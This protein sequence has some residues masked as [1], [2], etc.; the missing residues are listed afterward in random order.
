MLRVP[1]IK[2]SVKYSHEVL[3]S[4]L[5]QVSSSIETYEVLKNCFDKD[6]FFMQEQFIILLLNQ[7]NKII[8][9]HPLSTGGISSTV[10]DIRL[11]FATAIK[12][13]ATSIIIAHNHPSGNLKASEADKNITKKIKEAGEI[14]DIKLIDHLI[15][16]SESYLSFAD[17]FLL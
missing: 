17:E 11:I 9:Y 3:Q 13:L 4:E 8:G 10:V 5:R 12:S 14:L 6:T 1:Q 7:S 2:L 16:T 15:L